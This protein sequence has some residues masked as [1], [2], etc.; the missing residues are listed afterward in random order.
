MPRGGPRRSV[1]ARPHRIE[2]IA[3]G[4]LEQ[5]DAVVEMLGQGFFSAPEVE[6]KTESDIQGFAF[7]LT[8]E[9]IAQPTDAIMSAPEK[10]N[11]NCFPLALRTNQFANPSP[12]SDS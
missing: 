10:R 9:I 7:R 2:P 1:F 5:L 3:F 11:R 12:P 8:A 6:R 4:P